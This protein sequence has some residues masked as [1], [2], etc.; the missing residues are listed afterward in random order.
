MRSTLAAILFVSL[1]VS[2]AACG[3]KSKP[4][5]K[6]PPVEEVKDEDPGF[7]GLRLPLD[8]L[9]VVHACG[10]VVNLLADGS[11]PARCVLERRIDLGN[12]C[13]VRLR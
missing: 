10:Q 1:Q 11:G 12:L 5:P 9:D 2:L 6:T 13:E 3:G 7:G 4:P 8:V